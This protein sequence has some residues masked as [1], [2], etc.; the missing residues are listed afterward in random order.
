LPRAPSKFGNIESSILFGSVNVLF[1]IFIMIQFAYLFGGEWNITAQGFTYAEY[2]RKGF[3]ELVTVAILSLLIL[4]ISEKS[5]R[6]DGSD[7]TLGFKLL[8]TALIVQVTLIMA[9]AFMRLLLYEEAYGFTTMRLYSHAF[10]VW[11][12]V[13]FMLVWVKIYFD[14]RE[15]SFAFRVF[16]SMILFLAFMN[17]LNPDSFIAKRNIERYQAT[18]Q[19]D[20]AYLNNLSDDA[21]P[22]LVKA[23]DIADSEEVPLFAR[24]LVQRYTDRKDYSYYQGWQSMNIA[25][26][27]AEGILGAKMGELVLLEAGE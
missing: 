17:L 2:A 16:V 9:S 8:S 6:A 24:K 14:K 20:I 7:H 10:V 11:L 3:G 5:V 23:L 18:G 13:V 19:L 27:R 1:F 15:I 26:M 12:A 22:E 4:L 21:V 25:R